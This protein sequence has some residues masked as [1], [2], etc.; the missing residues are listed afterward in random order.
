MNSDKMSS[1]TVHAVLVL[2]NICIFEGLHHWFSVRFSEMYKTTKVRINSPETLEL[3]I[4]KSCLEVF[5]DLGIA[6]KEAL[7]EEFK[8]PIITAP[9]SIQNDSGFDIEVNLKEGSFNLHESHLP[10]RHGFKAQNDFVIKSS[11]ST[12]TPVHPQDVTSVTIPAGDRV[13][14]ELKAIELSKD[15]LASQAHQIDSTLLVQH[16]KFV[17]VQVGSIKKSLKIPMH[18]SDK[19]YFPLYRDTHEEAWGIVSNVKLG[20]GTIALTLQ[21]VVQITNHFATTIRMHRRKNEQFEFILEIP[22]NSTLNVPLHTIYNT[23]REWHF[24]LANFKPSIQGIFWKESPTDFEYKK[25]LHCDPEISYEPF[26][27]HVSN[28]KF[29][30]AKTCLELNLI[31]FQVIRTRKDLFFEQSSTYNILSVCYKFDLRPRVSIRNTLPI[32]IVISIASCGVTK[33]E[34][35]DEK[36]AKTINDMSL[37]SSNKSTRSTIEDFLDC[38]EKIVGPGELL[39]LPTVKLVR[40]GSEDH[41]RIVVR[42]I[43]YLE[44]DWSCT[45]AIPADPQENSIWSFESFDTVSEMSFSLGVHYEDKKGT[46]FLSL[47]CPFWMVNKTGLML[48]YR[49]SSDTIYTCEP[50]DLFDQVYFALFILVIR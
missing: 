33:D 11:N 48:S 50:A 36:L 12:G 15:V 7:K 29:I 38:G 32:P 2:H 20:T 9:Y 8:P 40:A 3:T 46:L 22:P 34:A 17:H 4:T 45:T 5:Q 30:V 13:Y 41:S 28:D 39:H 47:Y 37:V 49:V 26:Y 25:I 19:R 24:S 35:S 18:K 44:K 43:Q 31:N 14:L 23:N 42:L 1:C 21:G 16:A 6:F 27:I 10:S